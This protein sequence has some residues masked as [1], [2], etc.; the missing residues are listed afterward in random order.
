MAITINEENRDEGEENIAILIEGE[1]PEECESCPFHIRN[2]NKDKLESEEE[3]FYCQVKA[4]LVSAQFGGIDVRDPRFFRCPIKP[5][6]ESE[7]YINHEER[8]TALEEAIGELI[9]N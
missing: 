6:V 1:R 3:V 9:K 5:I 7:P 8:I 4:K 2:I